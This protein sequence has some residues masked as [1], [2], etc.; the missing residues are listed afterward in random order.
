M[1]A[2]AALNRHA[3]AAESTDQKMDQ[4]MAKIDEQAKRIDAL[5]AV[6]TELMRQLETMRAKEPARSRA[7]K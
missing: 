4:V 2:Q 6:I 3:Q 7:E 1:N 5:V